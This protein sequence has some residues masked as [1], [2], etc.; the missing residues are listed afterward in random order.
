MRSRLLIPSTLALFALAAPGFARA[1]PG[2][3]GIQVGLRSLGLYHGAID[4]VRGPET[5]AAVQA[6]QENAG[7]PTTGVVDAPTRAAL[8]PLGAPSFGSRVLR[9]GDFGLDVSVLQ[10]LL[11]GRG[12]Y[13][14]ALDGFM[15]P[16]TVLAVR[17]F[18][19]SAHLAVDGVVGPHTRKVLFRIETRASVV[20]KRRRA[21]ETETYV[22]QPGDSLTAI[23]GEAGVTLKA[24]AR[25]NHL[26]PARV[27]LIGTRLQV[28]VHAPAMALAP[29]AAGTV[30]DR[31]DVWANRLGV[32]QHLVRALAWM[33]S[34]FQPNV[35]SSVG[36]R[37]VLQTLPTT[38]AYVET[39]LIGHAVPHS[40]DGDIE[41]GVMYLKHLLQ[42]FNGDESL[43]LAG[44][45][46]GERA[47]RLYG[48]YQVTKP[49]VSDV[50]ALSARM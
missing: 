50:L 20:Q 7:L 2:E 36:A 46:Q 12:D 47:V 38:R 21:R 13:H 4:G 37:G 10:V 32:S 40:L 27:L 8:G 23:A 35:V 49:F 24:L 31:L 26:D 39:V 41:V 34:G 11:G 33:E 17:R 3:A 29:V 30:R 45:Y 44:W 15:G 9:E 6:L 14:G 16:K 22:V 43:A 25:L 5:I 18:Q 28:P 19:R 48:P 1:S 42:V